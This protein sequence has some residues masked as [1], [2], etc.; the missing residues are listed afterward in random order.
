MVG[1]LESNLQMKFS[2]MKSHAC[3]G[4]VHAEMLCKFEK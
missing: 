2:N 1:V 3:N 4:Q